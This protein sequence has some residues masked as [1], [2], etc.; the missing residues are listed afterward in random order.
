MAQARSAR[1]MKTRK[2]KK[3]GQFYDLRLSYLLILSF[4]PMGSFVFR[5]ERDSINGC[6][7]C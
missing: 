2:E 7:S 6:N 1:A 5:K 3:D 4:Y